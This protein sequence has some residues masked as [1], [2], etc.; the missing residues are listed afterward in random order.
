MI[1]ADVITTPA[2]A[3][4]CRQKSFD[5]GIVVSASH[6]PFQDNGIKVFSN[7]GMK[8]TDE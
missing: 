7:A 4:L 6:N 3:I 1:L 5:A 8:L 2:I